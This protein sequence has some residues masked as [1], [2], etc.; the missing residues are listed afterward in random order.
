MRPSRTLW[1]PAASDWLRVIAVTVG[2][3]WFGLA[4][5]VVGQGPPWAFDLSN[6]AALWLAAAFAAGAL[7]IRRPVGAALGLVC[8][9][10]ALSGYYGFMYQVEHITSLHYLRWLATPWVLAACVVG[11][12]FGALGADWRLRRSA[13]A[14]IALPAAFCLEGLGYAAIRAGANVSDDV[15]HLAL[16]GTG[17]VLGLALLGL[18]RRGPT[19]S[20]TRP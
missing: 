6:V 13:T 12:L 19:S 20:R 7:S 15:V 4:D 10:G 16:I 17:T 14:A 3:A 2:G 1:P 9:L 11:P 18:R 8:L 5:R